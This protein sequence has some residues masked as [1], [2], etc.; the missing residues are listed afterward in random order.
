MSVLLAS[1]EIG[2]GGLQREPAPDQSESRSV[3]HGAVL[4]VEDSADLRDTLADILD[5]EGYRVAV[6]ANGRE[7]L[8]YL[9]EAEPPGLVILDLMMPVMNGWEFR[10]AQLEDP[11]LAQVPVVILSGANDVEQQARL[12]QAAAYLTKP[13]DLARLLEMV[14]RCCP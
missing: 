7:A 4:I 9:H 11:T 2:G 8:D 12:L 5:Y 10:A 6:A 14:Q 3:A 1:R 13:I